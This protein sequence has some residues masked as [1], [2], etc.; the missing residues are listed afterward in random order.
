LAPSSPTDFFSHAPLWWQGRQG[1][2]DVLPE[3]RT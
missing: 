2:A 1:S 3:R